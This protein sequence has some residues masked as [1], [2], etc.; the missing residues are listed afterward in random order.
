MIRKANTEDFDQIW[1]FFEDIIRRGDTYAYPIDM[2][3]QA[4]FHVWM[5]APRETYV[6]ED[7][8]QIIGSYYI[9]TNQQGP[10]AH[11]CNCGYIVSW[12]ARGKGVATQMCEHSQQQ[13]KH[14]GYLAMQFNFVASSNTGAVDLW[15]RLGFEIVGTL[16]QAFRHPKLDLVDA[17]VMYKSL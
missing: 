9:K 15:K 6:F 1:S 16:P 17:F 7:Q 10:G 13:A 4:A 3:K 12:E 11:V 2:D 5:E 14:L 8:G